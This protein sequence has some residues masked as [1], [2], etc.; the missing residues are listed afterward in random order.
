MLWAIVNG[1][2]NKPMEVVRTG[3]PVESNP[4]INSIPG[5]PYSI[6]IPKRFRVQMS[7]PSIRVIYFNIEGAAEK[8]RLALSYYGIPFE[9][10]RPNG[11]EFATLRAEGKL[12]NGQLPIVEIDGELFTQSPAL[13]RYVA[14][15]GNGSLYSLDP[16]KALEIDMW[17]D[18]H[19]DDMRDFKTA[20][21]MGMRPTSLGHPE[22]YHK[23]EEGKAKVKQLR[24]LYIAE[25]LPKYMAQVKA[26]LSKSGGPF[27]F[28]SELSIADLCWLCRLRYFGKGVADHIPKDCLDA[29]PEVCTYRDAIMAVPAVAKWYESH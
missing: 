26:Q 13:A 29:Y 22:D 17:M 21:Y 14:K 6:G 4:G 9:D 5:I 19:L 25:T 23:T 24:E 7:V 3:V 20:L 11:D 2:D 18:I 1:E 10:V 8:I 16:K 12:P 28:G 15:L 27:L